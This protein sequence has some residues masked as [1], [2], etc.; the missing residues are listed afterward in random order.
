MVQTNRV[1]DCK[2]LARRAGA[3]CSPGKPD[4]QGNARTLKKV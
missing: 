2:G 4:P 3:Q 1:R